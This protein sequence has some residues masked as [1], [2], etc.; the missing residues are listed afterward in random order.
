MEFAV[1]GHLGINDDGEEVVG[2]REAAT[3]DDVCDRVRELFD[4]GFEAISIVHIEDLLPAL[5]HMHRG[6]G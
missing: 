4:V 5:E 3:V 2:H 6:N 1:I